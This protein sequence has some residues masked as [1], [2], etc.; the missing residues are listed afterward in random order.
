MNL[1][2]WKQN[3]VIDVFANNIANDLFSVVQPQSISEFFLTSSKD[4]QARKSRKNIETRI[5]NVIKQIKQFRITNSLGTY[6]KAR[7]Q[8]KFNERLKELGYDPEVVG[9]LNELILVSLP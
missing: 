1:F 2:F 7:L 9:K 4:T 8:L 6:G 3:Q 5:Y